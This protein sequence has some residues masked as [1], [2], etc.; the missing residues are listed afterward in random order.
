MY[1]DLWSQYIKVRKL[2]KRGNYS[3]A[4]TIRGNTVL[5]EFFQADLY[6]AKKVLSRA[7]QRQFHFLAKTKRAIYMLIDSC[8]MAVDQKILNGNC[9]TWNTLVNTD[10]HEQTKWRAPWLIEVE[11]WETP[12]YPLEVLRG[13]PIKL[14]QVVPT[15]EFHGY[16][17]NDHFFFKIIPSHFCRAS[18]AQA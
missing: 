7:K 18:E 12:H 15:S 14:I 9:L 4:E 13:Q 10:M 5:V 17:W 11:R 8:V 3:R 1:C 2:F 6:R 16:C